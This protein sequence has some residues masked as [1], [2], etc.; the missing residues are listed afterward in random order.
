MALITDALAKER[1]AQGWHGD[2]KYYCPNPAGCP[3]C[4][5]KVCHILAADTFGDLS[6]W[7]T[8]SVTNL[9]EAFNSNAPYG[10]PDS[11]GMP[12]FN[13]VSPTLCVLRLRGCLLPC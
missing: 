7:D 10:N 5:G 3:L 1:I 11:D 6:T 4:D 8:S 12:F 9:D 2:I 13:Q